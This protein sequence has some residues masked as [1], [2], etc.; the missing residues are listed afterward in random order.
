V[1]GKIVGI[2]N[3]A[4]ERREKT[5][6]VFRGRLTNPR[7]NCWKGRESDVLYVHRDVGTYLLPPGG[8]HFYWRP[9]V[10]RRRTWKGW[11]PKV[12]FVLR[13]GLSAFGGQAR[14]GDPASSLG[15]IRG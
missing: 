8:D 15:T 4:D 13:N 14:R 3:I 10:I 9:S 2:V 5:K 11:Y 12:T 1:R 7:D 6:T